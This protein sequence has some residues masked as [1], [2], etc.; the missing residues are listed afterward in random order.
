MRGGRATALGKRQD[1]EVTAP[2]DKQVDDLTESQVLARIMEID[3]I[4]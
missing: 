2:Q 1:M 3:R 4:D